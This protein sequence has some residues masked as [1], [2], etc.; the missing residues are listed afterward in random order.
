MTPSV[1]SPG[2]SAS[3]SRRGFLRALAAAGG[4]AALSPL[5]AACGAEAPPPAASSA[6][7]PN[8][9]SSSASSAASSASSSAASAATSASSSAAATSSAAAKPAAAGPLKLGILLPFSQVYAQLG[10]DI[11]DAMNMYFATAGNKAG[12]R[13]I[14]IIKEDEGVDPAPAVQK[15]RKLIEQDKIDLFSGIVSTPIVYGARDLLH[16]N[17]VISIISNAGGNDLT[18]ARKSPYI[19][20]SSFSNWQ[21]AYA[22]GEW[23]AKNI[24]KVVST[25]AD[26]GA[27]RESAAA[28][29][30]SY[31]KGGGTVVKEI[32]PK[33]PNTDYAPYLPEIAAAAVEA[34]FN[35]YSGSDAVNFVKQYDEFGLKKNIKLTGSGFLVEEDV[36]PAQ[37]NAAIGAI[38]GLH[39]A[40]TLDNPENKKFVEEWRAKYKREP[41]VFAMAGYDTARVIVEALNKSNGDTSD[42][43]ALVKIIEGIKFA[44]PRGPFEFDP[45]THNVINTIY[46]REVKLVDG[47]P[48]N[49]VT[50]TLGVYKDPGA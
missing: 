33:F 21:S 6:S 10:N 38:T 19:F 27:G 45:A 37:G 34:T 13:T 17:K 15:M 2:D 7:K 12:G 9:A 18:R 1:G 42:K 11:L 44:S 14:E 30:E 4:G 31:V 3:V 49:V 24:K 25:A 23:E 16:N 40:K 47:K 8:A 39:W 22:M 36:L 43:D 26:Y 50:T 20:R 29:K 35:F 32:F 41:S 5:L 48:G 28:F 46:L